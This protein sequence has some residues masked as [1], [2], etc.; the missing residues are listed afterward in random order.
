MA[1]TEQQMQGDGLFKKA[2]K[3]IKKKA[4][5]VVKNDIVPLAVT[6][7][8]GPVAGMATKFVLK[9]LEKRP[10]GVMP[11]SVRSF[12][13]K[14]GGEK[15]TSVEVIRTPLDAVSQGALAAVTL[16]TFNKAVKEA[17]YDAAFHLAM[18]VNGKYQ[19]DKQE[20]IKVSSPR[21]E[22]KT[23]TM[24]IHETTDKTIK[25]MFD[26]A[27]KLMGDGKFTGYDA[28]TN[29]CQ[30]FIVGMLTGAELMTERAHEFVKQDAGEI[31][32]RL[33]GFTQPVARAV[34]DV[35]AAA[36]AAIFGQGAIDIIQEGHGLKKML[37]KKKKSITKKATDTY[38]DVKETGEKK[39]EQAKDFA[40][41]TGQ[42]AAISAAKLAAKKV[43]Q[44]AVLV[45]DELHPIRH[46]LAEG[47]DA[48]ANQL[49][50]T[51]I[52]VLENAGAKI[53]RFV[54]ASPTDL[55]RLLGKTIRVAS[56]GAIITGQVTSVIGNVM[57]IAGT[58]TGQPEIVA[59][60]IAVDEAG[61]A[62]ELTGNVG[63]EAGTIT[64]ALVQGDKEKAKEAALRAAI[65]LGKGLLDMVT[66]GVGSTI[67]DLIQ[68]IASDDPEATRR[69][70]AKGA[71]LAMGKASGADDVAAVGN[72][73]I[74][75]AGLGRKRKH[76]DPMSR[77][78][79]K[80]TADWRHYLN[81]G[82]VQRA[83]SN[84]AAMRDVR[85]NPTN[86]A[87]AFI[88]PHS[89]LVK[90]RLGLLPSEF[91]SRPT[92]RG[93]GANYVRTGYR[94]APTKECAVGDTRSR[95]KS[96]AALP[97]PN[98]RDTVFD[99]AMAT[100][101]ENSVRVYEASRDEKLTD[102]NVAVPYQKRMRSKNYVPV[103]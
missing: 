68:G 54:H 23:E 15:I 59:L 42:D 55:G 70:A 45:W 95:S 83:A 14:K 39:Y 77:L 52:D 4:K 29:N 73:G 57:V 75:M 67:V 24:V 27:Q 43:G 46:V 102:L 17:G 94:E 18:I 51:N 8:A 6:A 96:L 3:A 86:I 90:R 7:T 60:G 58:V 35:A 79:S 12:V 97:R 28:K 99:G 26:N 37:K 80:A 103:M 5:T 74:K 33:P 76:R 49:N 1:E 36:N 101:L 44:G 62:I 11:P 41:T 88:E 13:E 48:L 93:F 72:L 56:K 65:T 21:K 50:K 22:K 71:L 30:D 78:G 64:V 91:A 69:A 2:K 98:Y 89:A 34:T 19:I 85:V 16:G 47:A 9:R 40:K 10:P 31:F 66:D 53:H 20:V 92:V 32:S 61:T 81:K 84:Q 25:E 87:A 63:V 38:K 82:E 100:H